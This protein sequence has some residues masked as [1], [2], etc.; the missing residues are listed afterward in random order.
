MGVRKSRFHARDDLED[1]LPE[2]VQ[3]VER[4]EGVEATFFFRSEGGNHGRAAPVLKIDCPA[5]DR[6]TG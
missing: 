4:L 6:V 3:K 2:A 5:L 1:R